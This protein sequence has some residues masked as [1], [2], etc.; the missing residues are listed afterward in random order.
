MLCGMQRCLA[1]ILTVALLLPHLFAQPQ[2][3]VSP[4]A[5]I[6]S[7]DVMKY[8]KD[9]M[10]NQPTDAQIESLVATLKSLNVDYIAI[11]IPM[12]A[13]S[14]YDFERPPAPRDA[15]RFT[16]QFADEIH[17]QGLKVLWRGTW[18]GIEGLY[19]FEKRVGRRRLPAGTAES[20]I[21]DGNST[22]LGKTYQYIVRNPGFFAPGDIWA[23]LP[24]RTQ[25]IFQ[26]VTS[27]LPHD[28][29]GIQVNYTRFF[30][31]LKAVSDAAFA[32]IG[33]PVITGMTANNYTEV[34]SGWLPRDFFDAQG[35][36]AID[37]YGRTRAASE[38][39]SD[40][41]QMHATYGKPVFIQEWAD[42]WNRG[43]AWDQRLKYLDEVY[44]AM[45]KLAAEGI[46]VGMNYWGGWPGT[47]ESV[48]S[49]LD[50][51]FTLNERGERLA[52]FFSGV[53]RAEAPKA[54]SVEVRWPQ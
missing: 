1:V 49:R 25:D 43:L 44:A 54:P 2:A 31:D 36:I 42:Y 15:R 50:R 20:A 53:A 26:D 5:F 7:V 14:D 32:K 13:S 40:I 24:E 4:P 41:R 48:I 45:H 38:L 34:K 23:P 22:W 29:E 17:H 12:D 52:L 28:G 30:T 35:V 51:R 3:T 39:E 16:Q 8:T 27:F 11:S 21:T 19:G 6:R 37:Y 9:L 10:R 46:L 33:V 47:P 18:C